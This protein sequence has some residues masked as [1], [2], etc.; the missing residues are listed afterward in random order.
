[1]GTVRDGM[2]RWLIGAALALVSAWP[3]VA[4]DSDEFLAHRI[5][6]SGD[7]PWLES[8]VLNTGATPTLLAS[9]RS[10]IDARRGAYF[11]LGNIGD[12]AALAA[13]DRIETKLREVDLVPHVLPLEEVTLLGYRRPRTPVATID[14]NGTAFG[15]V[16]STMLG[17]PDIFLITTKT[18]NDPSS[19]SRPRLTP[20]QWRPWFSWAKVGMRWL[21]DATLE[22]SYVEGERRDGAVIGGS[23]DNA[24]G[25]SAYAPPP[26]FPTT[27]RRA[28]IR[29]DDVLRDTDGDGWTDL[30]EQA[31]G[32]RPDDPDSDD[33]GVP[34]GRDT[35]PDTP[36][37]KVPPADGRDEM[38]GRAFFVVNGFSQSR[39][40]RYMPAG[41]VAPLWGYLGPIVRRAPRFETFGNGAW[42]TIERVTTTRA[43]V[44][45]SDTDT[46]Y[47][48]VLVRK[49]GR[50]VATNFAGART[51]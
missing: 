14:R 50:W 37:L 19:W 47:L 43:Q 7:I 22:V 34:D 6:Q 21:D 35:S 39:Y 38:L 18:P 41:R 45:V 42:W 51:C 9:V 29:V 23:G 8:I 46:G 40:V 36:T 10:P 30:E 1:M 11:R 5:S 4:Q 3:L 44:W 25:C 27:P 13:L 24:G 15:I 48:V 28:A 12:T 32:I 2:R 20:L 31:L 33:D 26:T 16:G 49:N 17:G